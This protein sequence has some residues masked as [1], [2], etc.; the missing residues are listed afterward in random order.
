MPTIR[1]PGTAPPF[2]AKL[3]EFA[4]RLAIGFDETHLQHDL[5]GGSDLNRIDDVRR[6][7]ARDL[8]RLIERHGIG[9][10]ARQHDAAV[11]RRDMNAAAREPA[12]LRSQPGDVIGH[13]HIENADQ[14]LA[15]RVD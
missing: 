13:F 3:T 7:L 12:D 14:T 4:A 2:G 5:L 6:K 10:V 11:D 15:F 8:D 9:R 1:S